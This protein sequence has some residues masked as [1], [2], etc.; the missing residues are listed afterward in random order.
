MFIAVAN[1]HN[2]EESVA[3]I[4]RTVRNC[5]AAWYQIKIFEWNIEVLQSTVI[6]IVL[7][8]HSLDRIGNTV[9]VKYDI[10]KQIKI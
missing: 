2:L 9:T 8:T 1:I 5:N 7:Y 6:K 10:T 3:K 4:Q